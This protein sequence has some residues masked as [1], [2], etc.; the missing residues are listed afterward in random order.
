[1]V[2]IIVFRPS[3]GMFFY[4]NTLKFFTTF[5]RVRRPVFFNLSSYYSCVSWTAEST[6]S[7]GTQLKSVTFINGRKYFRRYGLR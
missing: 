3:V 6:A 5:H 4:E 7:E 1:V 2:F